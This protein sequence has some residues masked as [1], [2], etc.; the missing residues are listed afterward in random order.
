MTLADKIKRVEI[1]KALLETSDANCRN[2]S[3]GLQLTWMFKADDKWTKFPTHFRSGQDDCV[4][5]IH[6]DSQISIS[7]GES[8]IVG[9]GLEIIL[10]FHFQI[11][12][13]LQGQYLIIFLPLISVSILHNGK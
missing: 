7:L 4:T 2:I 1:L 10:I 5:V 11:L 8:I 12:F 13:S 3:P 9:L 6:I